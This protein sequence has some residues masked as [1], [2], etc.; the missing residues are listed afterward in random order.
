MIIIYG[1]LSEERFYE[2]TYLQGNTI[3]VN[4]GS[5]TQHYSLENINSGNASTLMDYFKGPFTRNVE[6]T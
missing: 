1:K 5:L 4:R 3:H 2:Y 6:L